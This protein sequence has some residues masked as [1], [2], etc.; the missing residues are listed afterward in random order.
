MS[1]PARRAYDELLWHLPLIGPAMRQRGLAD[2]LAQASQSAA[3]GH[4]LEW[5]FEDLSKAT[6]NRAL[7][8]RVQRWGHYLQSGETIDKAARHADLP[9]FVV[10]VLS[11]A[12]EGGNVPE[13]LAF[14]AR[15]YRSCFSRLLTLLHG[16]IWPMI[17]LIMSIIVG[18]VCYAL[19][20]PLVSLIESVT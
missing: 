18:I 10:G 14:L 15:Y 1:F 3:A 17:I 6:P 20:L 2:I 13:A 7:R 8:A 9:S 11:T 5:I 19:F 4:S 16:W 12:Q